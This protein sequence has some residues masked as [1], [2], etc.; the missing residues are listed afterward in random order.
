MGLV[1]KSR[2]LKNKRV[3][4][5]KKKKDIIQM[6]DLIEIQLNS[7]EWF[8]QREKKK[9]NEELL[10]QGLEQLFQ[11][12]FPIVSNDEKMSLEYVEYKLAED[13]IKYSKF[14]AKDKGQT[15][16]IPLKAVIN[17]KIHDT[18]EIRQ[19]E[20]YF[21]EIPLMTERGT[22]IINGAERVV[23][24]QIHRSPGVIYSFDEKNQVFNC[25]II[26]YKGS[27]L[28]FEVEE[29]KNLLFVRIDRKR[30]I[31]VT[32]FLRALGYDKREKIIELFYKEKKLKLKTKDEQDKATTYITSR[33]IFGESAE[34]SEKE[35]LVQ[36]GTRL[37]PIEIDKLL[38]AKIY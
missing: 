4:I 27:W 19:K 29:K 32:I 28:E 6:P 17:L 12:T 3:Q 2:Q 1:T 22:F 10:K 18:G 26:P 7:Y 20:I 37:T 9:S 5:G 34:S 35:K 36:A 11:E 33:D 24:S 15:Y 38:Q 13:N 8:L 21:G 16:S 14:D 31:L 23:V 30:K 25:R